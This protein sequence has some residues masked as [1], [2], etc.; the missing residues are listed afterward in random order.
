MKYIGWIRAKREDLGRLEELGVS[1]P[2]V[3][4]EN[5]GAYEY[6]EVPDERTI[7][8]LEKKFPGFWRGSFTKV[9][10]EKDV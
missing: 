7:R 10:E 1:G 2:M 3:Y 9:E 6:C 5:E 4:N 8:R